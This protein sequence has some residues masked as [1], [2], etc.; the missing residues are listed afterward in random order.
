MYIDLNGG[1][2]NQV[3][4]LNSNDIDTAIIY[5]DLKMMCVFC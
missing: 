3:T 5:R 4:T 1:Q 2:I